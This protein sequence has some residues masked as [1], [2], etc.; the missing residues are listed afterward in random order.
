VTGRERVRRP[1]AT[2]W[3]CQLAGRGGKNEWVEVLPTACGC[4]SSCWLLQLFWQRGIRLSGVGGK[5][6]SAARALTWKEV[7]YIIILRIELC[8]GHPGGSSELTIEPKIRLFPTITAPYRHEI[9]ISIARVY[10]YQC[11]VGQRR[12]SLNWAAVNFSASWSSL[13]V[14]P[15]GSKKLQLG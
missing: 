15:H 14:M 6:G 10:T 11:E 12:F 3:I 4:R 1:D 2:A 9:E 5:F 13:L 7:D 8:R